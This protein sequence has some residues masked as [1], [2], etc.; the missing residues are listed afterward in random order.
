[1]SSKIKAVDI[2]PDEANEETT[3]RSEVI[4]PEL[5]SGE[6]KI[7]VTE[8]KPVEEP[9]I[10][11]PITVEEV[12]TPKSKTDEVE[13]KE[14]IEEASEKPKPSR[15][16]VTCPDCGKTMLEKNFRYQHISVCGKVKTPKL[17]AKPIEEVIKEKQEKT[18]LKPKPIEPHPIE[19]PPPPPPVPDY[20]ELRRQYNNH[21]K[22]RKTQ[23]VKKNS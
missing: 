6:T 3:T 15:K 12:E 11:Q 19:Q 7:E 10:E 9:V 1:M 17:R 23:L 4:K 13:I 8:E 14:I 2:V 21:L 16:M 5:R 20:W 18:Q 22:D